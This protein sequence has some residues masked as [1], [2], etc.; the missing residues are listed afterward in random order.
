MSIEFYHDLLVIQSLDYKIK[1]HLSVIE[2]EDKRLQF[3]MKQYES[4][5]DERSQ[6]ATTLLQLQENLKKCDLEHQQLLTRIERLTQDAKY[7]DA[8]QLPMIEKE[9]QSANERLHVVDVELYERMER[10][11]ECQIRLRD[12]ESFLRGAEKTIAQL[13]TDITL[14]QQKEHQSI[15]QYEE[16]IRDMLSALPPPFKQ[17]FDQAN[18]RH[19]FKQPMTYLDQ[20]HCQV[21]RFQQDRSTVM[22]VEE[23]KGLHL[24]QGCGRLLLPL[25]AKV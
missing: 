17:A 8:K 12:H 20:L 3:L 21:C 4:R 7:A 2:A 19:R 15:K 25:N 5:S 1:E 22:E 16:R 13:K 6:S 11:E 24:C 14:L 18:R 9:I 23:G 10:E